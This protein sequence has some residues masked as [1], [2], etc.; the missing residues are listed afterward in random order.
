MSYEGFNSSQEGSKDFSIQNF[1]N[2][3]VNG[4]QEFK[5]S[6]ILDVKSM[7]TNSEGEVMTDILGALIGEYENA[8]NELSLNLDGLK[9]EYFSKELLNQ[10]SSQESIKEVMDLTGRLIRVKMDYLLKKSSN[11]LRFASLFDNLLSSELMSEDTFDKI[12]DIRSESIEIMNQEIKEN[13][14]II[15]RQNELLIRSIYKEDENNINGLILRYI[16]SAREINETYLTSMEKIGQK[17]RNIYK[18]TA[19]NN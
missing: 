17:V 6:A 1:I 7:S 13:E 8:F 3:L 9:D 12:D 15:T 10:I 5:Q 16:S 14:V 4:A 2:N 19:S 11:D 18:N